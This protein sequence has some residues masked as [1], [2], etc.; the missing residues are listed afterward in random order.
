MNLFKLGEMFY[1][2]GDL[3]CWLLDGMIE[4]VGW[5]DDQVKICGYW[6]EFEEIEKQLQEYSGVKDVVVVVDC[7]DFG[8]VLINVYFVN[9]MQFLV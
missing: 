7:Y 9:W 1:C 5:I 4:Y 6:I 8:D 2:I 3:V